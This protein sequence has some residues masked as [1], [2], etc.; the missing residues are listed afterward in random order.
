MLLLLLPL[1]GCAE[2]VTGGIVYGIGDAHLDSTA[3]DVKI[4][5]NEPSCEF[6]CDVKAK[7]LWGGM[8]QDKAY[9]KV[10]NDL[11]NQAKDNGAD[12]LYIYK[13]SKG[14]SGSEAKGRAYICSGK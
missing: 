2:A 1:C 9:Q 11:T 8:L 5:Q 10:I 12:T 13:S 7:T 3:A 14:F 6:V 4:V